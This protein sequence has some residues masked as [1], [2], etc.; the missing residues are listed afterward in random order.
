MMTL[1]RDRLALCRTKR[2]P[3]ITVSDEPS[4]TSTSAAS[5][6]AYAASTR[7]LGTDSPKNTTSGFSRPPHASQ[8]ARMKSASRHDGIAVG[9]QLGVLQ[10]RQIVQL[11]D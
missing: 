3:D 5:T 10:D 9:P 8:L 4:T 11:R 6:S 2:S 7:G 1:R